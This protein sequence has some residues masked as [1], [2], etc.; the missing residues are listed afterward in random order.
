MPQGIAPEMRAMVLAAGRGTRLGALTADRPKALVEVAGRPMIDQVINKLSNSGFR[1]FVVNLHHHGTML[2]EH[3]LN[4]PAAAQIA[5]S[6]EFDQLLDTGGALLRARPLLEGAG[7]FFAHNVDIVLPA[8]P[9]AMLRAHLDTGALFTLAV[10]DRK[11]SRKLLFDPDGRLCGWRDEAT[12]QL[13]R[14]A[15]YTPN[16]RA[17]AYSGAQWVADRYLAIERRQGAFSVVDAWL[18]LCG[19]HPV[20]A[21]QHPA[22]GWFDLGSPEKIARAENWMKSNQNTD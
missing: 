8:D 1:W 7:H 13:R 4:S 6:Q 22:E 20:V 19:Q 9:Q 18:D 5:F 3:L 15:N 2:R 16:H 11:S 12:G 14:A 17:L 21:F 10:S